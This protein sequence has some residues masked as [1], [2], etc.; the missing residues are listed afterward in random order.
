MPLLRTKIIC[1]LG[2]STADETVLRDIMLAGMHVARLNFSHGTHQSHGETI[3]RVKRM[4]KE[5]GLPIAIMLDTKGPEI[6][7]GTFAQKAVL[8]EKGQAFRLCGTP[9]EGTAQQASI[10]YPALAADLH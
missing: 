9:V 1:T 8:L 7:L 10:T 4:R 3:A 6:R 2:P 5:L